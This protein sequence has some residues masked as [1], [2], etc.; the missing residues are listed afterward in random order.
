M[1]YWI[2][3]ASATQNLEAMTTLSEESPSDKTNRLVELSSVRARAS[4]L[5]T[6]NSAIYFDI[7][8]TGHL[9]IKLVAAETN[10]TNKVE[11]HDG[12]IDEQG[13]SRMIKLDS[14][15]VPAH[16]SVSLSPGKMH[17]MLFDLDKPISA[18]DKFIL[19]LYFEDKTFI[20]SEVDVVAK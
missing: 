17:I 3:S 12:F 1:I 19:K 13:V 16:T 11:I 20:S 4:N 2:S 10:V 7:R 15:V 14:L 18:G 9:P 8:N 5:A 6:K